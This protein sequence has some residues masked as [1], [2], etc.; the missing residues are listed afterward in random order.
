M[1]KKENVTLKLTLQKYKA[2]TNR[3]DENTN[4]GI[5]SYMDKIMKYLFEISMYSSNNKKS[6]FIL[7][8]DGTDVDQRVI[9]QKTFNFHLR[10]RR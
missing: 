2:K 3:G 7:S 9:K 10:C 6:E 1:A 5:S 4:P 8:G